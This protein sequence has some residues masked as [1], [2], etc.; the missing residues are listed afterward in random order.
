M[1]RWE[2]SGIWLVTWASY[3]I[4]KIVGCP[5]AGNVFPATDWL[6]RKQLLSDPGMHHGTCVMHVPWCRSGLLTRGGG[7]NIPGI[8]GACATCNFTYLARDPWLLKLCIT[9]SLA[10]MAILQ[11]KWVLVF[12]NFQLHLSVTDCFHQLWYYFLSLTVPKVDYPTLKIWTPM[13]QLL[14]I[15]FHINLSFLLLTIID[16]V[17]IIGV[18]LVEYAPRIRTVHAKRFLEDRSKF[19]RVNMSLV[20]SVKHLERQLNGLLIICWHGHQR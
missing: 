20:A 9:R 7:E 3:Q 13:N 10:A 4:R 12:Q 1:L 15:V 18:N 5:C 2:Y 14:T 11:G 16:F 6:Q 17:I 8:P 19:R